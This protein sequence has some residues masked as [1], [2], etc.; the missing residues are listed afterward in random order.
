[1][2]ITKFGASF[3]LKLISINS[4]RKIENKKRDKNLLKSNK[5]AP[6]L[7]NI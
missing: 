6:E 3:D 1:M 7:T 5:N 2:K 4:N